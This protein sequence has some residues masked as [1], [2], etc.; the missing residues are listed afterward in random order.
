M[1]DQ[2]EQNQQEERLNHRKLHNQ[3][4]V[5][6]VIH[7]N[8]VIIINVAENILCSDHFMS[9]TRSDVRLWDLSELHVQYNVTFFRFEA[10]RPLKMSLFVRAEF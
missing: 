9:F 1:H 8:K 4:Y 6:A 7:I 3:K 10:K 2:Q 5:L